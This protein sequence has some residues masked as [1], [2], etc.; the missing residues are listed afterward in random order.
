MLAYLSTFCGVMILIIFL[1]IFQELQKI[2]HHLATQLEL[3]SLILYLHVI[4][5]LKRIGFDLKSNSP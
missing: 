3:E 4:K 1:I 2:N 5:G